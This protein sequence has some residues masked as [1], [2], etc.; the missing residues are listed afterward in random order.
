MKE[1]RRIEEKERKQQQ[2]KAR[3]EL[4]EKEKEDKREGNAILGRLPHMIYHCHYCYCYFLALDAIPACSTTTRRKGDDKEDGRGEKRGGGGGRGQVGRCIREVKSCVWA[5]LFAYE[6]SMLGDR[7]GCEIGR[8]L[9][10][11][12]SVRFRSLSSFSRV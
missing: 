1:K 11:C 2:G 6:D 10:T 4:P 5:C 9:S 7:S 8:V 3:Q 12:C